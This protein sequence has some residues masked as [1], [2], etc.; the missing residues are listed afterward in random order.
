[1]HNDLVPDEIRLQ[2][3]T[4]AGKKNSTKKVRQVVKKMK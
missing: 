2:K 4:H 1:M 3:F